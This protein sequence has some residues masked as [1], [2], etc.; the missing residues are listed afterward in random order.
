MPAPLPI[1][2]SVHPSPLTTTSFAPVSVVLIATAA[3]APWSPSCF[4]TTPMPCSILSI[5]SRSPMM[6]VEHTAICEASTPIPSAVSCCIALASST[7]CAPVQAL[8]LPELNTTAEIAPPLITSRLTLTGAAKTLLRVNTAAAAFFGPSLTTA[9][10]SGL[11]D[12]LMPAEVAAAL[13][14]LGAVTP[15]VLMMKMSFT[16][17]YE[18]KK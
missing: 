16:V 15:V 11:P 13:N 10:M 18:K 2:P 6:P 7:P 8:A 4:T 9:A 1:P 12:A 14:P 3:S 17:L 5:G